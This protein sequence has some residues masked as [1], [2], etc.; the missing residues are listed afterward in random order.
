MTDQASDDTVV[1]F[2]PGPSEGPGHNLDTVAAI[3][4]RP[5]KIAHIA[6]AA[7]QNF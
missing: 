5:G 6:L 2:Y 3:G 4:Q 7:A 1:I